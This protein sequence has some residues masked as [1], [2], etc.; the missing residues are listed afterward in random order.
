MCT[1]PSA[2]LAS[3]LVPLPPTATSGAAAIERPVD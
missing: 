3:R 1:T 2:R